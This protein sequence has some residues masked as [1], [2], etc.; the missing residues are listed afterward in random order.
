V[1][2]RRERVQLALDAPGVPG[3]EVVQVGAARLLAPLLIQERRHEAP[4]GVVVE[5]GDAEL[6]ARQS[7]DRGGGQF[8]RGR[9][10]HRRGRRADDVDDLARLAH[11]GDGRRGLRRKPIWHLPRFATRG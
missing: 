1:A 5:L 9:Q 7:L 6:A 3:L 11:R 8:R 10:R 4:E 2:A